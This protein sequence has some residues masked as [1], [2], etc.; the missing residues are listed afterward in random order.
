M[1]CNSKFNNPSL[2]TWDVSK[3]T[4]IINV[5]YVLKIKEETIPWYKP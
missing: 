2:L 5:F 3:V 4:D 1:F